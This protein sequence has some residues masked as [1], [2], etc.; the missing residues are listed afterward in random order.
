MLPFR[1]PL[2]FA[3]LVL[4]SCVGCKHPSLELPT[5]TFDVVVRVESDPHRPLAGVAVLHQDRELARTDASGATKVTLDGRDGDVTE[6]VVRCPAANVQPA[7]IAVGL[8]RYEG[9]KLSEYGVACPPLVRRAIVGVRADRGPNLPVVVLGK[10]VA[11]TDAYG[12]A[13]FSLDVRPGESFDVT[14]DTSEKP[15]MVPVSPART[16]VMPSHDDILV[17]SQT[18]GSDK[19]RRPV[20]RGPSRGGGGPRRM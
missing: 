18:F 12:A 14:L 20:Y 19:P 1:A 5:T 11:R 17:F 8:H 10:V 15:K 16:F 6:L 9:A 4:L 3:L 13:H 7:P 2:A